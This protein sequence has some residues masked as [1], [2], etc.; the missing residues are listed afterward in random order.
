MALSAKQQKFIDEYLVSFN[1]TQAA[2]RA[3]YA[4]KSAHAIG[5]ENLRKPE[6]S[7]EI[8]QRLQESAMTADEVLMRLADQARGDIDNYLDDDGHFDLKKAR[9]AKKTGIIKKLKTKT[10]TRVIA[11]IEYV[12][13]EVEFE[14]YDA[15]AALVQLGRHHKLFTDKTEMDID[16]TINV[17]MDV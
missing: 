1:A 10:T 11:D 17:V 3:G 5:W 8:S 7:G 13:T 15:Q 14:L 6:I 9:Q 12:T 2:L 16:Q 4:E